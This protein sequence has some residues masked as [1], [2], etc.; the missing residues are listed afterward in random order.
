[1]LSRGTIYRIYAQGEEAII[2]LV[3]RLED[4]IE[5]LEAQVTRSPQ[6]LIASLSK[7]LAQ[8]KSTISRQTDELLVAHQQN[9]QLLSRIRELER[10]V[11]SG[12]SGSS[13]ERDSHNSSLPPSL[14][15]PW[16]KVKRTRSLRT[17]S[18]RKVG[19]QPGHKGSTLLQ[20]AQPDEITFHRPEVCAGCGASL[21]GCGSGGDVLAS[22]RR[23]VFDIA[24][25][26]VKVTEHRV[27]TLLGG[28][29]SIV[30]AIKSGPA[31]RF[32]TSSGESAGNVGLYVNPVHR[33]VDLGLTKYY[34]NVISSVYPARSDLPM[35]LAGGG[36]HSPRMSRTLLTITFGSWKSMRLP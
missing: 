1:V 18:G 31:R 19:G 16:K 32:R 4:R 7:E 20:V 14:D 35:S 25:G 2:A 24:D 10:E 3:G 23:Q 36:S 29:S 6:P 15:L 17:K 5:D 12:G 30:D 33:Q 34:I 21:R 26:G 9:H 13:V 11:E 8:A 27:E 22:Q 28:G